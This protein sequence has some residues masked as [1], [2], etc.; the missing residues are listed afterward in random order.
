MLL[1]GEGI[2]R[3]TARLAQLQRLSHRERIVRRK[4]D[5]P[6]APDNNLTTG[7]FVAEFKTQLTGTIQ[8]WIASEVCGD[9][10]RDVKRSGIETCRHDFPQFRIRGEL[11]RLCRCNRSILER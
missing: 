10:Y 7:V 2:R 8:V 9:L 3:L 5:P 1:Q 4:P 11:E 6:H